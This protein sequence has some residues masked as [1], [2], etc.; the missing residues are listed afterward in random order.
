M[1]GYVPDHQD[2][3]RLLFCMWFW[4]KLLFLLSFGRGEMS[5]SY[6]FINE[7]PNKKEKWIMS[8]EIKIFEKI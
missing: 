1:L 3:F 8:N 6:L 5:R 7:L 2:R 4:V